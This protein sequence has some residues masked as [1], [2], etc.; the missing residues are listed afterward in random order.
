MQRA[1]DAEL[2]EIVT[3]Q[4]KLRNAQDEVTVFDSVGFALEDYST[5]MWLDAVTEKHAIAENY[6]FVPAATDP[7][8][9][10]STLL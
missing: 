10:F 5:L 9:L 4:K 8:D 7:K 6:D 3:G 2:W 1:P